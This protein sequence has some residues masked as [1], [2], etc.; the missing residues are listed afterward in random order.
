MKTKVI[1]TILAVF[2]LGAFS[3][4]AVIAQGKKDSSHT[5]TH[6]NKEMSHDHMMMANEPHHVL[7]MSYH[8]N[9][10]VFA[11]A[12][13]EQTA[14]ATSVNVE[15]ARTSVAEMRRCFD[16]MKQHHQEHMQTMSA[17]M[18]T[19]MSGMMQQ[20]ETH[21]TELNSQL[22]AL[23]QEVRSTTPEAKKVATLAASI[24]SHLDAMSKM[25]EG[26]KESK[27][28]MKM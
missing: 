9:L 4:I 1:S 6:S 13:H 3:P 18:Q 16:Q 10:A 11:K 14:R 25:H 8:Q 20:M 23:E 27:M 28:K 15:F 5:A 7:A 17:E 2:L 21:Q 22:T 24:S 19:K 26:G 12:L